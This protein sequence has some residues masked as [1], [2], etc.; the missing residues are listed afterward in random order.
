M[1]VS[2]RKLNEIEIRDTLTARD[3]HL[4]SPLYRKV[5]R[6]QMTSVE[7]VIAVINILKTGKDGLNDK[8][9]ES[10][11]FN[12]PLTEYTKFE[13]ELSEIITPNDKKK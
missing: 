4:F 10:K 13:K 1:A 5:E 11:I 2:T 8:Q 9:V 7:F 3:M 12:M 6:E